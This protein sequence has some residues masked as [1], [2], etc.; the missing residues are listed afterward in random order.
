MAVEQ[1]VDAAIGCLRL[2]SIQ[3]LTANSA[4]GFSFACKFFFILAGFWF[5]LLRECN[6]F[7]SINF[8]GE[9]IFSIFSFRLSLRLSFGC[10]L[11]VLFLKLI[12]HKFLINF[13]FSDLR[14]SLRLRTRA[15]RPFP[16]AIAFGLR[17]SLSFD[18]WLAASNSIE[19]IGVFI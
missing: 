12:Y 14:F 3:V 15:V 4:L 5:N 9:K 11:F 19:N 18:F 17:F 1:V 8:S 7:L 6:F 10:T 16:I 13:D 2:V